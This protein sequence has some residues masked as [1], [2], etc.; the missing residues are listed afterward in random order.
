[1][2]AP[3]YVPVALGD[4]PRRAEA[5]I[6]AHKWRA[7][8]PGDLVHGPPSGPGFGRPG[9]DQGYAM[10]LARRL[11][12]RLILGPGESV[13]DAVAGAVAVALRRASL[14]GRAPVSA[15]VEAAFTLFGFLDHLPPELVAF[16]RPYFESASHHYEAQ[17]QLADLV[18]EATLG[19]PA[20]QIHRRLASDP[21]AWRE[22]LGV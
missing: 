6:P 5:P 17:R 14:F 9:P 21:S 8:R 18:P 13:D 15:D 2:A 4:R 22:L 16:R 10:L 7:T 1:M 19:L 11:A 20:D 12:D 3:D